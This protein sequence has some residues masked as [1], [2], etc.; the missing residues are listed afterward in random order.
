V[1]NAGII[2]KTTTG[3]LTSSGIET[4][5]ETPDNFSLKQN[6]PNPFNPTTKINYEIKKEG[7][8]SLKIYNVVGQLV[9]ELVGE[10][11]NAGNYIVE[12][13]GSHLASG[14]YY[15]RIEANDFVETKKMIL[16]K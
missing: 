3:G 7:F 1:G 6:Y 2:L 4:P 9:K 12:F 8:V 13:N 10:F 11:K 5:N 16:I 14:T 15:Y